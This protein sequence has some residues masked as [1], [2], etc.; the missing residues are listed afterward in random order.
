MLLRNT[1]LFMHFTFSSQMIHDNF[2]S[3]ITYINIFYD[4]ITI[5][6]KNVSCIYS[7]SYYCIR[8]SEVEEK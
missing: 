5:G 8:S 2:S 6:F 1:F 3:L 4:I 7:D